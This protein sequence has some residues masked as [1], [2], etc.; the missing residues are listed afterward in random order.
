MLCKN[1]NLQDGKR[2]LRIMRTFAIDEEMM[3]FSEVM[4]SLPDIAEWLGY[5]LYSCGADQTLC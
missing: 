3:C 1:V 2:D 5:H 4:T